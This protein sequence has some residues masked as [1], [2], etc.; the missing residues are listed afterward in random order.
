MI[1]RNVMLIVPIS[2]V[3]IYGLSQL[4]NQVRLKWPTPYDQWS[5][6]GEYQ[7]AP[8]LSPDGKL[9]IYSSPLTGHG[10]IYVTDIGTKQSKRLTSDPDWEGDPKYSPDQRSIIFVRNFNIWLMHADGSHPKALTFGATVKRRRPSFSADGKHII[11]EDTYQS[12]KSNILVL[13]LTDLKILPVTTAPDYYGYPIMDDERNVYYVKFSNDHVGQ[14]IKSDIGG[15]NLS[16]V[17]HGNY[18]I[19]LSPDRKYL[20]SIDEPYS[21]TIDLTRT[22]DAHSQ[23]LLNTQTYKSNPTFYPDSKK[24]LFYES[25]E[26][27]GRRFSSISIADHRTNEVLTLPW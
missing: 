26:R 21:E 16:T 2:L 19:A 14:I 4:K 20:A 3:A 25:S 11:F 18:F 8:A 24:V 15:R 5:I 23:V 9:V 12:R 17:G 1:R 6:G 27:T 22:R 13:R 10:D 7:P